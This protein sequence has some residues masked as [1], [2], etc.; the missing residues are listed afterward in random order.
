KICR[1]GVAE[2]SLNCIFEWNLGEFEH[3]EETYRG[4]QF[5]RGSLHSLT[6]AGRMNGYESYWE[7]HYPAHGEMFLISHLD[8]RKNTTATWYDGSDYAEANPETPH[9]AFGIVC[10]VQD[11]FIKTTT[12][13]VVSWSL[14]QLYIILA[15]L[16]PLFALLA[17][18][19]IIIF[20][21]CRRRTND[22][23]RWV[24]PMVLREMNGNPLNGTQQ[25]QQ[26]GS[27]SAGDPIVPMSPPRKQ[28][29]VPQQNS[30]VLPPKRAVPAE[31]MPRLPRCLKCFPIVQPDQKP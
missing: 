3:P 13:V 18:L 16:L 29:H 27:G 4:A 20:C 28:Q 17:L 24:T 19:I 6:G 15:V 21:C 2:A 11:G 5:F 22:Q 12:K 26:P 30:R 31:P 8:L 23:S 9:A 7:H 10:E 14:E 25:K 1:P